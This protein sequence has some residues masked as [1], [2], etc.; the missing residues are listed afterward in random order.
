MTWQRSIET[1]LGV[2]FETYLRRHW[3]VQRDVAATSPRR[4]NAGWVIPEKN[5]SI[6]E[7][8]VLYYGRHG[9]KAVTVASTLYEKEPMKGARRYIKDQGGRLK[10][11]QPN[12]ISFY[13]KTIGGVD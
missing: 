10:I 4:L 2:S 11:D 13:I 1:S 9:C 6:D 7:S 3:D 8:M 12:A 5:I